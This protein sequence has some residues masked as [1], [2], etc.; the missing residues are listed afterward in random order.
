MRLRHFIG[1]CVGVLALATQVVRAADAIKP[2]AIVG[3]GDVST[4]LMEH[5]RSWAQTNLAVQVDLL[6]AIPK[7]G[8]SLDEIAAQAAKASGTNYS[9][10]VA[11][12]LPPVGVDNH[13]MRQAGGNASVVNL[14]PMQAD[15]P[16]AD[17]LEKRIER[18]TL[19]AI[20]L[21]IEV[22][23]CVNPYCSLAR[24]GS[25]PELDQ[26]GRNFCPPCLQKFQK[27]A[28]QAG[29]KLDP[30]SPFFVR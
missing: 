28:A 7:A 29:L 26:C 24:Y 1:M 18:Q 13:G 3:V 17:V 19:R 2:V 4:S 20:A 14:R 16:A 15:K 25:L 30:E 12:A 6:P 23:T 22:E 27:S 5:V 11:V 10:V 8:A 21:M 9:R